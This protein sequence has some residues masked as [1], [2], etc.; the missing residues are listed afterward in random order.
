MYSRPH[1]RSTG[2]QYVFSLGHD[3]AMQGVG[4]VSV[5]VRVED[6]YGTYTGVRAGGNGYVMDVETLSEKRATK[7]QGNVWLL[8]VT[9]IDA[10]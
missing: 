2:Q 4:F 7:A 8:S 9:P 6:K 10:V 1:L 5:V 3:Y